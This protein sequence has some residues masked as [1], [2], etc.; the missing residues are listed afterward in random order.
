MPTAFEWWWVV[1][2]GWWATP[3][4]APS[5]PSSL[6]VHARGMIAWFQL[7]LSRKICIPESLWTFWDPLAVPPPVSR[8][9]V[10]PSPRCRCTLGWVAIPAPG[11]GES[12]TRGAHDPKWSSVISPRRGVMR[13]PSN[14]ISREG[15]PLYTDMA[16]IRL[17]W[18]VDSG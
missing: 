8:L 9:P 18:I 1:W 14:G 17:E 12:R 15:A 5:T 16:S 13:P 2:L 10:S 6:T 4:T 7:A 11:L 3:P